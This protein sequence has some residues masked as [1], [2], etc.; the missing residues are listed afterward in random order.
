[1]HNPTGAMIGVGSPCE[2]GRSPA[3]VT[4]FRPREVCTG[5]E[6]NLAEC[7]GVQIDE[8]CPCSSVAVIKFL[9]GINK[10]FKW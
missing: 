3:T 7:G 2:A 10:T 9:A 1:M 5:M 8:A 6:N 4:S